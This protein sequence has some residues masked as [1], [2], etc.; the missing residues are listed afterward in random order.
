MEESL[1]GSELRN[2]WHHPGGITGQQD[3]AVGMPRDLFGDPVF[4][5]IK[6]V[7]GTGVFGDPIIASLSPKGPFG[8]AGRSGAPASRETS[9]RFPRRESD[10]Q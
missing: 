10:W 1:I 9:G 2:R 5:E 7:G 3:D 8:S 6:W 4:N